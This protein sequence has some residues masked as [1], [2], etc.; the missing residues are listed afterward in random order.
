[1]ADIMAEAL[2]H[3]LKVALDELSKDRKQGAENL[4]WALLN[5]VEFLFNY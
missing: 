5:Q 1:M 2:K 3:P 4:Q